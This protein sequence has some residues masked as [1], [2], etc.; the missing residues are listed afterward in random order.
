[1]DKR[2]IRIKM[3][4]VQYYTTLIKLKNKIVQF[5]CYRATAP[6]S[7]VTI[8]DSDFSFESSYENNKQIII[9]IVYEKVGRMKTELG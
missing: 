8:A 7:S 9:R 6:P 4:Y 1:M 2:K 5:Y 3:N